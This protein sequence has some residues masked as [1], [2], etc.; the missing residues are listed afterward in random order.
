MEVGSVAG[1]NAAV[2]AVDLVGFDL[3]SA[4]P[5]NSLDSVHATLFASFVGA[6]PDNPVWGKPFVG[7]RLGDW[8]G[9]N[10]GKY[11]RVSFRHPA[12]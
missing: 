4:G 11:S 10:G 1:A 7:F 6:R 12:W 3:E 2:P 9:T 8:G 5:R